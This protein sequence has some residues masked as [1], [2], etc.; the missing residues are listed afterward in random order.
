VPDSDMTSLKAF[1][2]SRRWVQ[3]VAVTSLRREIWWTFYT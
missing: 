3:W 2:Y 1:A